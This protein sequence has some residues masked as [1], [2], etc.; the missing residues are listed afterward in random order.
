M[1][2]L[3]T[4]QAITLKIAQLTALA[5][6]VVPLIPGGARPQ[7]PVYPFA[8]SR[9]APIPNRLR[10]RQTELVVMLDS[11]PGLFRTVDTQGVTK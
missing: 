1:G 4:V 6:Y 2:N 9:Q 7:L 8:A 5:R 3:L 10:F 11:P